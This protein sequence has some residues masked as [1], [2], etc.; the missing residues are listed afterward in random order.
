MNIQINLDTETR[1]LTVAVGEDK[2]QPTILPTHGV[3][4]FLRALHDHNYDPK[5][6]I[7][8]LPSKVIELGTELKVDYL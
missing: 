5:T 6:D 1:E 4:S 3:R 8:N 2:T 7:F